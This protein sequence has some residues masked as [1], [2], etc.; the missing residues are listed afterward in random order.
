[1]QELFPSLEL[2]YIQHPPHPKLPF[3]DLL[4][5]LCEARKLLIS[6]LI[7]LAFQNV[8]FFFFLNSNSVQHFVPFLL[9]QAEQ[10]Y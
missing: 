5:K 6:R 4:S 8:R 7:K 9:Q 3:K 10:N 2:C 1:M